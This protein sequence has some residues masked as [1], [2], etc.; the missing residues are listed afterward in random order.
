MCHVGIFALILLAG[1]VVC[2][3]L[4]PWS[5]L[6]FSFSWKPASFSLLLL[7]G[8]LSF[9]VYT[10]VSLS[11]DNTIPFQ[12]NCIGHG[13]LL[14]FLF[15]EQTSTWAAPLIIENM[16]TSIKGSHTELPLEY[17]YKPFLHSM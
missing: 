11:P 15:V 7:L 2:A 1:L 10:S 4:F 13:Q 16:I 6:S 17:I 5:L 3:L 14:F 9:L 12:H 8:F